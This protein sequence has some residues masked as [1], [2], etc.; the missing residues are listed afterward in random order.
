MKGSNRAGTLAGK[1]TSTSGLLL[2]EG[3]H[4]YLFVA[5]KKGLTPKVCARFA[6]LHLNEGPR[7][8]SEIV[9]VI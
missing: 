7:S 5:L 3:W 8:G 6:L 1:A 4:D 9:H 2:E